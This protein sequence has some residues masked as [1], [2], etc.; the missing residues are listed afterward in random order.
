MPFVKTNGIRL[1][2]ER[3]GQGEPVLMIM[4]SSASGRVWTMHQT[5]ALHRAGFETI[6]FDNRGMAPS[7]SPAGDYTLADMAADTT[8]LIEELG[9]GPCH[10][11]GASM[12]SVIAQEVA[13]ARPALVRSAVLIATR[14]RTDVLRRA[15][16]AADRTLQEAGI[17]LPPA[18]LA[19]R[20]VLEML[21][22]ATLNDDADI[23][24]WLELFELS[25]SSVS[26][27]LAAIEA[28]E[29]RRPALR[30]VAVPCRAIAFADDRVC[31][32][33]L[34]AEV[35]ETIPECD[36]VE[37]T[38]AG[39][40]GHLERPEAVNAAIVEFLGANRASEHPT[41]PAVVPVAGS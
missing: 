18:Y 26:G 5:P 36:L 23:A 8:G 3:S 19:V 40:L 31:P 25:G 29:D 14:A 22:P 32:P 17:R 7:D 27:Q 37:I 11:V 16:A 15:Q 2:Y 34:V 24:M 41:R 12:G 35:A 28:L 1:S 13:L 9:L 39:H 38:D 10:L 33:H 4:G 21:S 20:T 30:G 6:T